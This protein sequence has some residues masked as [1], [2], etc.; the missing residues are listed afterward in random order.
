MTEIKISRSEE[1]LQKAETY[2]FLSVFFGG[3]AVGSLVTGLMI[4]FFAQ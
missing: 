4:Y 3:V 1:L 2:L